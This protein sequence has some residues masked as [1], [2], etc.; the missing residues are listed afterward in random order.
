MSSPSA[1]RSDRK[2]SSETSRWPPSTMPN[3]RACLTA[4]TVSWPPLAS[5]TTWALELC[6]CSRYE[7]KSGA[8]K[9]WRTLPAT[10]PPSAWTALA[11][12]ASSEWPK[13]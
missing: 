13:A 1:R 7:A 5:A 10:V 2:T 9:G 6:A 4:L 3:S 12:S 8:F 11:V